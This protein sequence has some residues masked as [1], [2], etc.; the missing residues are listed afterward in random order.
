MWWLT[1]ILILTRIMVIC[2]PPAHCCLTCPGCTVRSTPSWWSGKSLCSC[3]GPDNQGQ[4]T[5]AGHPAGPALDSEPWCSAGSERWWRPT[6]PLG[7]RYTQKQWF[8]ACM[9]ILICFVEINISLCTWI[10]GVTCVIHDVKEFMLTESTLFFIIV[11]PGPT[12]WWLP[13]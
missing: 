12:A 5:V 8:M 7:T 3:E 13:N 6:P 11:I 2:I 4:A 10:G 1:L 9:T